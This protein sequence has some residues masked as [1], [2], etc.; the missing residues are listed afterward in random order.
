MA[1]Q[2]NVARARR[3]EQ[4]VKL[5]PT[6]YI[7]VGG[8]GMEVILRVRRRILSA[9]WG[10]Q[11]NPTRI[12]TLA[13][14]PVAQFIHFDLDHGAL[15][16]SGKSQRTDPLADA[17][18]LSDEDRLIEAFEIERYSRSDDDLA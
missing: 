15:V 10:P 7:G 8:T 17:V 6:L 3:A 12:A 18:K 14:F 1:E 5:R 16:E 9:V 13:E 2:E 11:R 4:I